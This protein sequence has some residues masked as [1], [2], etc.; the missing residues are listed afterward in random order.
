MKYT[1]LAAMFLLVCVVIGA[2]FPA[3]QRPAVSVGFASAM[4]GAEL[5]L[6]MWV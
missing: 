5:A 3:A 2:R 6:L 1:A 4:V